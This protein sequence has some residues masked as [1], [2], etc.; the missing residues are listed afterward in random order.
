M[1]RRTREL[2]DLYYYRFVLVL[3]KEL[4]FRTMTSCRYFETILYSERGDRRLYHPENLAELRFL[5]LKFKNPWS[6]IDEAI[7]LSLGHTC[8]ITDFTLL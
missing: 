8:I 5:P 6:F 4:E 3:K 2:D 1:G 7:P